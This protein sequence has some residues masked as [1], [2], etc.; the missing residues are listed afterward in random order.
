MWPS[1][2]EPRGERKPEIGR[3]A[4]WRRLSRI[5]IFFVHLPLLC[6][7][8]GI[9]LLSKMKETNVCLFGLDE[10]GTLSLSILPLVLRNKQEQL[11]EKAKKYFCYADT[12]NCTTSDEQIVSRQHDGPRDRA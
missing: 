8:S 5:R 3:A 12:T 7:H 6:I 4:A 1:F 11:Q 10:F 9:P 2:H